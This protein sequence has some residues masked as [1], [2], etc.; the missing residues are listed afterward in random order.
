MRIYVAVV[1]ASWSECIKWG[2]K[3]DFDQI[4]L[5]QSVVQK[6]SMSKIYIDFYL[7]TY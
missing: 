4:D 5:I 1:K 2:E 3:L 7:S 6:G